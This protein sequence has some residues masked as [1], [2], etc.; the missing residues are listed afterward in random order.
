MIDHFITGYGHHE[1]LPVQGVIKRNCKNI[2]GYFLLGHF[3]FPV[4]FVDFF[5]RIPGLHKNLVQLTQ[6]KEAQIR[7]QD[8]DHVMPA[9]CR[10][11]THEFLPFPA[12]LHFIQV[13]FDIAPL[14]VPLL[15]GAN[16]LRN[17]I[18]AF[19]GDFFRD[20]IDFFFFANGISNFYPVCQLL[21]FKLPVL[22][23]LAGVI[24]RP[25]VG[26][27]GVESNAQLRSQFGFVN[28]H[29][30]RIR[31]P[32]GRVAV[33]YFTGF[34]LQYRHFGGFFRE[35]EGEKFILRHL[36]QGVQNR[37]RAPCYRRIAGGRFSAGGR[38]R[39]TLFRSD[40]SGRAE[41]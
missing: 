5:Q 11:L 28:P 19:A 16:L 36:F 21:G 10:V 34:F 29:G 12:V 30:H 25:S 33:P 24:H 39:Q 37:W 14:Q 27:R 35:I 20:N 8:I 4:V 13:N 17:L 23:T 6:D 22:N 15:R 18:K 7:P 32:A 26:V 3:V 31:C 38:R 40:V 1:V 2:L 9:Q 41:E